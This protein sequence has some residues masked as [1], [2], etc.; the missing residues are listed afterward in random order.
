M[1]KNKY[2]I[3]A[4][5][6]RYENDI[7]E[8][9]CRH[10][11]T[12]ADMILINSSVVHADNTL[13]ILHSLRDEGLNI[14]P[15]NP[16]TLGAGGNGMIGIIQSAFNKHGA[17]L[18]LPLDPD[19]F[20]FHIDGQNPRGELERLAEDKQVFFPWRNYIYSEEPCDNTRFLPDYFTE[21]RI[22]D[23]PIVKTSISR[24]MFERH[25]PI[26]S[27]GRHAFLKNGL[28]LPG[29]LSGVLKLA[30]Y[31][32]RSVRQAVLKVATGRLA[33]ISR[34]LPS[35]MGIQWVKPYEKIKLT[36]T[37]SI[38]EVKKY[39]LYYSIEPEAKFKV[40]A[41]PLPLA[42]SEKHRLKYTV[43]DYDESQKVLIRC[44]VQRMEEIL[45]SMHEAG[46]KYYYSKPK[47]TFSTKVKKLCRRIKNSIKK[48]I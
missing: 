23:K 42:Y 19:E 20:L 11:L 41:Q 25:H 13:N 4:T 6:S 8:S 15:Y 2:I 24:S 38:E 26:L 47:L 45:F 5:S 33:Y 21:C 37:L 10:T 46:E 35:N 14:I 22:D 16:D 32:F 18:V 28:C 44:L 36:G 39:S 40:L 1:L 27:E 3:V 9:F 30:H 17:D 31:P 43:Y 34:K 29:E 7:I 12:F 48:R